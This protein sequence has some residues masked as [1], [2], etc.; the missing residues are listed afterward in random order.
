MPFIYDYVLEDGSK[1]RVIMDDN[2]HVAAWLKDN[3]QV[4]LT[5]LNAT[6][7]RKYN[8]QLLRLLLSDEQME[9]FR[10]E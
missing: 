9:L 3:P 1:G 2:D 10:M 7:T 6:E 5:T 8:N 4:R